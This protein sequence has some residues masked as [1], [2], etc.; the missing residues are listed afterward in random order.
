[1]SS[2]APQEPQP[3][4]PQKSIEEILAPFWDMSEGERDKLPT[5]GA[6]QHDHYI[7]GWPKRNDA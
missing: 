7:Y 2:T 6:V 1:M 3:F 4:K 5:D